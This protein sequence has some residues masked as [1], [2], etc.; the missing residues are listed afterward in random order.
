MNFHI[1]LRQ[2]RRIVA[3]GVLSGLAYE[4]LKVL[5]TGDPHPDGDDEHF[6]HYA[7][8]ARDLVYRYRFL[9]TPGFEYV[10]PSSIAITGY[11]PE[12]HYADPDLG[13]KRVHPEDRY[14]LE[15]SRR[16]PEKP[17]VLRWYRKYGAL[18]WTENVTSPSTTGRGTSSPSRA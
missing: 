9:P 18:I 10:S 16:F 14:L 5:R 8:N 3:G 17:L 2:V 4:A 6:R 13:L 15:G 7:D 11:S 12:E 1:V